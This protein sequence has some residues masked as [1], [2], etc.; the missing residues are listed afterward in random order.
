TLTGAA[1]GIRY[2]PGVSGE[3][4]EGFVGGLREELAS[5]DRILPGGFLF[6]SDVLGRPDVLDAAGRLFAHY[7]ARAGADV[8]LTVETKGIP[9]AVS[10]ARYL[11]LP[12]VVVRRNHRVTEGSAVSLNYVSGSDRRIQTMSLSRR[13]L[14]EGAKAL[15]ID[16]FMKAGGTA[17]ALEDLLAEFHGEAVGIGVF[18][19]TLEPPK[20][21]VKDYVSLVNIGRVDEDRREVEILYGTYFRDSSWVTKG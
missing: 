16:D 11:R 7:F 1:G 20:K 10:T 9:L 6:M 15:I 19:A 14:R 3:F 18:M 5:A 8:V 2:I 12:I 4:A 13:S 21:L 17:R